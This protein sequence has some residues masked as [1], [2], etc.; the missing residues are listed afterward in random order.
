MAS[1]ALSE[2]GFYGWINL[3]AASIMGVIGALYLISFSY[4]LP[5]LIKEFKWSTASASLAS[6]INIIAMGVF[7]PL[8]GAFIAKRGAK[9][10]II[11]GN[12]L[13]LT[14]FALLY[15]HS[16]LWELFLAYGVLVGVGAGF[17]GMLATTTVINNWF[18]KKRSMALGIFLGS[19]GVAGIFTGRLLTESIEKLGWRHTYLIMSALILLINIIMPLIVIRNKPQDMGQ[20]PDGLDASMRTAKA[21]TAPPQASYRTPVDFTA[22]EAIRTKALWLLVVYF[23]FSMLAL[24]ALMTHLYTHMRIVGISSGTAAIAL[25][26]MS[27]FM[28]LSNFGTGF[29]GRRFSMHS[30]AI[31]A[32]VLKICAML[33]IV[34]TTSL[35]LVFVYMIV[36]GLGF[37]AVMVAT[38]NMFPNY[39]GISNYPQIMGFVRLF[40]AF[41]GGAGAPLA[42]WVRDKTGS[43]LPAF[44]GALV[45][46][47]LGLVC[48]IFAKPPMHPSLKKSEPVEALAAAQN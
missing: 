15:F 13:G 34:L 21:K 46:M 22:K 12:L 31:V 42:G 36:L 4:F 8:A 40:W 14:G 6:T 29:L 11:L 33:I 16:R 1:T 48:L 32:E 44:E 37:G 41:S 5:E 24:Q 47:A 26:V 25:G 19:G 18:V 10:S 38:M 27:G 30:I 2:K 39:F 45:I 7:G 43:F 23:C 17:G 9:L 3:A 35:P 28:A 20:I